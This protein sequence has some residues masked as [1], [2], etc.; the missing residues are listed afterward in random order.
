MVRDEV[1]I[2]IEIIN[3]SGR[4]TCRIKKSP[5]TWVN[6]LSIKWI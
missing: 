3:K 4:K 1:L 5:F 2:I 6:G